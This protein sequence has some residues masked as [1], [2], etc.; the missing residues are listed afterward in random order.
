MLGAAIGMV[1]IGVAGFV[2][3]LAAAVLLPIALVFS[4][5]LGAGQPAPVRAGW[6][7]PRR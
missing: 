3:A 7:S 4:V 1:V 6:R 2:A 5:A